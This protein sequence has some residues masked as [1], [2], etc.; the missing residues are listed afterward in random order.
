MTLS[1]TNRREPRSWLYL[2]P[3][4]GLGALFVYAGA[5]KLWDVQAFGVIIAR[6]HLV[7][8]PLLLPAA[9]GLP[10]LEVLAGLGLICGVR[11]SLTLLSALLVM[12]AG[13]LWFGVL[14]GLDIDCGCF[15]PQDLAEHDGLRQALYRDLALLA[16]AAYLY[17]WRWRGAIS[18]KTRGWRL[19]WQKTNMREEING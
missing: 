2:L 10:L 1:I 11:G 14:E 4:L 3:R 17:L 5:A 18:A 12:F 9:V 8:E 16:V 19:I 13:V 6:Y 15:A 7:P